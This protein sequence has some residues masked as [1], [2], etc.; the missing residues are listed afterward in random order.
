MTEY[1]RMSGVYWGLTAVDLM[2]ELQQ[3][4]R[5]DVVSFVAQC[6]HECGGFGASV[7]HDPHLLYTLSA[8]QV[9][10]IHMY[11]YVIIIAQQLIHTVLHN[12]CINLAIY[13]ALILL[14][15]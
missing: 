9:F 14:I 1:L 5:D 11:Y 15:Y 7:G 3:M 8:V 12:R 10:C 6:Q 4:N 2:G 13:C